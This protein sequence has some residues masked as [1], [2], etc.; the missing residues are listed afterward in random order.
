[1]SND[2]LTRYSY[3]L[4]LSDRKIHEALNLLATTHTN[5][6]LDHLEDVYYLIPN[7]KKSKRVVIPRD[8]ICFF[9]DIGFLS[10]NKN[11]LSENGTNYFRLTNVF[12]EEVNR[13]TFF[14]KLLL[15]N[16]I[17]ALIS[18][19]FYGRGDITPLQVK[20][21]LL[22]HQIIDGNAKDPDFS[23]FL[24]LIN[25]Y[26]IITYSKKTSTLR[27]KTEPA[28]ESP[29]LQYFI[30]PTLPFSNIYH[31]RKL[32]RASVGNIY[33]I[34]KHFRKDGFEIII[35]SLAP[36]G[37]NS[38]TIISGADNIS[39]SANADYLRLKEELKFRDI[40]LVWRIINKDSFLSK[41]HDRWLIADN[42]AYNIPPVLAIKNGQRSE[43]IRTDTPPK[44]PEFLGHSIDIVEYKTH[45]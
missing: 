11:I 18:Q 21:L 41:W 9:Q 19:V 15:V 37:V 22:S 28:E 27:I 39:E 25:K 20:T 26:D 7:S 17:I 23:S 16:P 8:L 43:I 30:E 3:I 32:L 35:D 13:C 34:D 6:E 1:M 31:M 10:E 14:Q 45:K 40:N 5:I 24:M 38:I 4:R 12:L 42:H 36:E 44:I 33:W 2:T 29:L